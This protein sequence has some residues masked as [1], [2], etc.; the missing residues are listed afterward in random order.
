MI[1]ELICSS[2]L[3]FIQADDRWTG[4]AECWVF[5]VWI[6]HLDWIRDWFWIFSM[7]N[8]DLRIGWSCIEPL[9][10]NGWW[11]VTSFTKQRAR[12]LLRILSYSVSWYLCNCIWGFPPWTK[13]NVSVETWNT[14]WSHM[15]SWELRVCFSSLVSS[16]TVIAYIYIHKVPLRDVGDVISRGWRKF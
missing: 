11:C 15:F 14:W 4:K 1:F 6:W 5:R 7:I 12:G 16:G 3:Y 10:H 9:R 2:K 8:M 13:E